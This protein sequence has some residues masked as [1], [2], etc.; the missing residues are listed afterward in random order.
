MVTVVQ[1]AYH[2]Q[3]DKEYVDNQRDRTDAFLPLCQ[4]N[5]RGAYL[6]L[7]I[8]RALVFLFH[9][10]SQCNAGHYSSFL[11]GLQDRTA[12]DRYQNRTGNT[13]VWSRIAP[14]SQYWSH[15]EGLPETTTT[16]TTEPGPHGGWV[17]IGL[18]AQSTNKY[19]VTCKHHKCPGPWT[20][21]RLDVVTPLSTSMG[22][23]RS[24]QRCRMPWRCC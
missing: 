2:L 3:L 15:A 17:D 8:Y 13:L 16:V 1:G 7:R 24:G 18:K 12:A 20:R 5:A 22:V 19:H 6:D 4:A 11:D 14:T 10:E 23:P 21:D 9:I